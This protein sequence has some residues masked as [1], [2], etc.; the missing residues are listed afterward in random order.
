MVDV[1]AF[2]EK[3][4]LDSR[5]AGIVGKGKASCGEESRRLQA[6]GKEEARHRW[7]RRCVPEGRVGERETISDDIWHTK[8]TKTKKS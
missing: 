8:K 5:R 7:Q 3:I 1:V 4:T 6:L 2:S